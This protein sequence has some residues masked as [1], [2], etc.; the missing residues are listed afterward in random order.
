MNLLKKIPKL[1]E[2]KKIQSLPLDLV[3]KLM[4]SSS[5]NSP[6]MGRQPG[7]EDINF[8]SD[9]NCNLSGWIYRTPEQDNQR[10]TVF[11][12]HGFCDTSLSMKCFAEEVSKNYNITAL[13]FDHRFHGNSSKDQYYPTFGGHEVYDV[14]AAMDYAD[15][16]GLPKP[17]ILQGTSLGAMAA[18]R[19]GIEDKR[20]AGVFLLSVPGWPWKAIAINA[21]LATPVAE[22]INTNYGWKVLGNGDIRNISQPQ[23]HRPLVCYIMG[24]KD[25]YDINATQ[26]VFEHWHH[27]ETGGYDISIKENPGINKFFYRVNGAIHPDR[28]GYQVWDWDK[29][30]QV[31]SE[32][33]NR[34]LK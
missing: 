25:R 3:F 31:K 13:A 4:L 2:L 6:E 18:Q 32:F 34:I 7:Y 20:V 10:G 12:M 11:F 24:D 9:D 30:N 26:E 16:L 8:T 15:K 27:G 17:Y 21:Y 19:A 5:W 29:F 23:D 33:F 28:A 22:L 14:Q 1:D